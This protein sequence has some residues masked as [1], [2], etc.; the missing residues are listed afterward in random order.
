MN[1]KKKEILLRLGAVAAAVA[2][3]VVIE[4]ISKNDEDPGPSWPPADR[5]E[6]KYCC[7]CGERKSID[8]FFTDKSKYDQLTPYC[9]QCYVRDRWGREDDSP[10]NRR[11]QPEHPLR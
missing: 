4:L 5:L 3:L 6:M 8:Y 2:G 10:V 7:R 11:V 9:K 1:D